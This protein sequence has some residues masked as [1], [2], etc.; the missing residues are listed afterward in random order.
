M[1]Q[2]ARVRWRLTAWYVAVLLSMLGIL[3]VGLY[4]AVRHR[5]SQQLDASL[6]SATTALIHA[7]R[8]REAEQAS[9]KRVVADAVDELHI[10]DRSLY[11]F[12]AGATPVRP[13]SAPDWIRDAAR[14]AE[15][16]GRA[17]RDFETP[18]DH[19][20]RLHAERFAGGDG[21]P[22]IAVVMADRLELDDEYASL[23]RAFVTAALIAL[24][25]VAAGGYVLVR[26]ATAPIER[27]MDRM[28]R[29]MADAAHEL[30]TPVTILRTRAEVAAGEARDPAR[31]AATLA[32]IERE[33]AR[34]GEIVGELLTLARADAGER[35]LARETLYLDDAAAGAVEGVRALAAHKGVGLEVGAFEEA[36]VSGDPTLIRQLLLIV[37]DNAVK[38][39]PRGGRVEVAVAAHNGPGTAAVV[40]SDT[41]IGIPADQLPH[42][43]ERFY[44]GDPA[45]HEAE[46]AGLGLAIARWIADAHGARI[47]IDSHPGT[48]TRVTLTFPTTA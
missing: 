35:L 37:L 39:T 31:D 42:V 45:R 41:G 47:A 38:F 9:P 48:G 6:H 12:G 32:A 29:F 24:L 43:F 4:V 36:K 33:A 22:E 21:R 18:E 30:R 27:T 40:V 34:I 5:L 16:T 11:L 10:P 19:I 8:I 7:A 13:R 20:V 1:D 2:L 26:Q 15:Q 46:G 23:I 28:R 44:R 3:G 14:E 25:L 17:D